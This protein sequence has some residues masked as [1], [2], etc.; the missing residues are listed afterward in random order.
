MTIDK[1]ELY[2]LYMQWVENISKEHEWK[3]QFHPR[4]IV[5]AIAEIIEKNPDLINETPNRDI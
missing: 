3:T 5:N 1:R 4:E 2:K